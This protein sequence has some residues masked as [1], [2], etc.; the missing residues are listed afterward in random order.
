M[1]GA[2]IVCLALIG[3]VSGNFEILD[4]GI[5]NGQ[6]GFYLVNMTCATSG[7]PC[8]ACFLA[9]YFGVNYQYVFEYRDDPYY[10]IH[11]TALGGEANWGF[12]FLQVDP[13]E[14]YRWCLD[15]LVPYDV[16]FGHDWRTTICFENSFGGFMVPPECPKP[17]VGATVDSHLGD[18]KVRGQQIIYCQ[19]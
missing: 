14:P 15:L 13:S 11:L 19:P 7:A 17:F 16:T 9:R 5:E 6:L 8:Q 2:A 10:R 3:G 12:Y 18:E 4:S 1:F